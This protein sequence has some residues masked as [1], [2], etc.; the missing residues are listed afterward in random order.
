MLGNTGES[1]GIS[2]LPDVPRNR[3]VDSGLLVGAASQELEV[4][5][6]VDDVVV[7]V[8]VEESPDLPGGKKS[9]R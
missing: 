9:I 7:E 6:G 8:A 2:S 4:G 1:K 5:E 3:R